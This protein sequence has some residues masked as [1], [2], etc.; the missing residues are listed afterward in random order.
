MEIKRLLSLDAFRGITIAAMI[1]VNYPGSWRNVY[2]PLLHAEWNGITPTDLI[3]PFFL[4]IV[5]VSIAFAYTKRLNA[6]TPIK[7]IYIKLVS[8]ALKIYAV[9][10]FL[11]LFPDFDFSD[12]RY[13]GVLQRIAVVF[14]FSGLLFLRTS[15]KTQAIVGIA[16][17]IGYWLAMTLIPTPGFEK[18]M[19]EPGQNLAAWADAKWLPGK[20]WQ[21]TWDPEGIL[22]TLPAIVTTI[23]GML[24]G[25]FLLSEKSWEQKVIYLFIAGFLL[26]I[27]GSVWGWTFPLNKNLWT[28]SYVLY[29]SGLALMTFGTMIYLVD[30]LDYKKGTKFGIIYGSNAITVY[31][32]AGILA[33]IFYDMKI[34]GESLNRYFFDFFTINA[35]FAPKLVS[36]LYALIYVGI[37]YIPASILYR[38]KI[39]IKL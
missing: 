7:D 25:K 35:G 33:F 38:K 6:G 21:G 12:L 20:M 17:L 19:L 1:L 31:V 24:T 10:L 11:N 39:F 27:T 3:Y 18:P 5:G 14:L 36:L 26:T 23:T 9:G 29:T 4:F 2:D 30:V 13:T 34:G 16:I 32:L 15:W 28:S 8:R 22:S 37:N